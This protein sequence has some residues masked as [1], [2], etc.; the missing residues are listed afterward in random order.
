M[1]TIET[2]LCSIYTVGDNSNK[3]VFAFVHVPFALYLPEPPKQDGPY[4]WVPLRIVKMHNILKYHTDKKY[5]GSRWNH[6]KIALIIKNICVICEDGFTIEA[7]LHCN[8]KKI[9]SKKYYVGFI[10]SRFIEYNGP[11]QKVI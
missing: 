4:L 7:T 10:C 2:N 1:A 11:F 6:V 8:T 3:I 9:A 5:F